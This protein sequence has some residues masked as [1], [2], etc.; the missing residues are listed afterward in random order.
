MSVKDRH[1]KGCDMIEKELARQKASRMI[2]AARAKHKSVP[3]RDD[4]IAQLESSDSCPQC[5]VKYDESR[6]RTRATLQ[7]WNDGRI[8]LLCFSCNS[9]HRDAG[10]AAFKNISATTK[11]CYM[12]KAVLPLD[13]FN[14]GHRFGGRDTRCR[15]CCKVHKRKLRD[16][17][18]ARVENNECPGP[19]C[20]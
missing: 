16:R 7:H 19:S 14:R 11:S 4:L 2:S 6:Q 3:D 8:S 12:C 10:D 9:R 20:P 18:K 1:F 13:A 15:E 17:R 5:G